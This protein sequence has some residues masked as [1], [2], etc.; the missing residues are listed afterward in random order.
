MKMNELRFSLPGTS[1]P[2][3]A[4]LRQSGRYRLFP[5]ST[6][7]EYEPLRIRSSH[8]IPPHRAHTDAL[9]PSTLHDLL[10]IFGLSKQSSYV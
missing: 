5:D 9:I 10:S 6:I 1:P 2:D 4:K 3:T 7:A 8:A